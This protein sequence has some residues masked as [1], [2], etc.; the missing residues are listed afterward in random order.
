[1]EK[2]GFFSHESPVA[3]KKTPWDRAKLFNTSASGENIAAG[4]IEGAAANRMWWHSP[5]HHKN[6]LG[7]HKR[8]GV[9]RSG[10][11]WT[12]LFGG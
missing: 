3:G 12:E 10:R 2:M 11:L 7:D 5:G 8:V 6:M 4:V 1:M 9:G